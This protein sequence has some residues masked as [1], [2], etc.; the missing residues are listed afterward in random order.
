[1]GLTLI[2]LAVW[3]LH[4]FFRA[5]HAHV[6]R[7]ADGL[8]HSHPHGHDLQHA[9]RHAPTLTGLVHGTAGSIGLLALLSAA[10]SPLSLAAAFSI[11]A[12]LAMGTAG[13]TAA[14]LYANASLVGL[15][16]TALGL[17]GFAG[18]ILGVV[19]LVKA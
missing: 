3:R 18:L 14:R 12:L 1:M 2:A 19:W 13:W 8:V 4:A 6:H 7:H 11:G 17:T 5:P 10:G 9:H 15:Q 16:R